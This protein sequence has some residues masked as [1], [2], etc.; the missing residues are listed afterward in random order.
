MTGMNTYKYRYLVYSVMCHGSW[1][2][3]GAPWPSSILAGRTQSAVPC[4]VLV[5]SGRPSRV[6][7][8]YRRHTD[9][10]RIYVGYLYTVGIIIYNTSTVRYGRYVAYSYRY[11]QTNYVLTSTGTST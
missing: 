1:P 9:R 11:G 5:R 2:W 4:A 8:L 6:A 3:W 10:L 7:Y